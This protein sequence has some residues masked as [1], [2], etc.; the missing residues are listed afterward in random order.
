M[1]MLGAEVLS[2]FWDGK[3]IGAPHFLWLVG[4]G[5]TMSRLGYRIKNLNFPT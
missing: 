5:L 1:G 3:K 4:V 2:D